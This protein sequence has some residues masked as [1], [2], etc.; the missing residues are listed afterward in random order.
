M[1][2]F[3]ARAAVS[4]RGGYEETQTFSGQVQVQEVWPAR[5]RGAE[6]TGCALGDNPMPLSFSQQPQGGGVAKPRSHGT[7]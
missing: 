4:P 6:G 5:V 1:C 3:E 7:E 2:K